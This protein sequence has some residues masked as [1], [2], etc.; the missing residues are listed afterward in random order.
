MRE[1][2]PHKAVA[3]NTLID[4]DVTID[5]CVTAFKEGFATALDITFEP[6][7]LTT[8][9]LKYV[10][11]IEK[12]KYANDDWNFKNNFPLLLLVFFD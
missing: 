6:M 5:E 9:Q 7:V 2:L 1:K 3:M 11:D 10:E 12:R 4:R 8:E